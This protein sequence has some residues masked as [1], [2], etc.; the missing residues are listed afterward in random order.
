MLKEDITPGYPPKEISYGGFTTKNLHHSPEAAKAFENTIERLNKGLIKD[1]SNLLKALKATDAYMKLNDMHLQQQRAESPEEVAEWTKQHVIA[2]D[3]LIKM[4]E[5]LHHQD[6]WNAHQDELL[7]QANAGMNNITGE[8]YVSN[9]HNLFQD[10]LSEASFVSD[11]KNKVK[12]I[13]GKDVK[14]EEENKGDR[15]G[16]AQVHA[17]DRHGNRVGHVEKKSGRSFVFQQPFD[18]NELVEKTLT[19]AELKNERK[20]PKSWNEMN[21]K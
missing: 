7:L 11:W 6:C 16:V 17:V 1:G 21:L 4:G 5:F 9:S 14:F 3:S 12:N 15:Y 19:S 2:K 8:M 20:L 13:H 18:K 10:V